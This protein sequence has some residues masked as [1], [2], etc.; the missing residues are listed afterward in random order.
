MRDNSRYKYN[1]CIIIMILIIV[2]YHRLAKYV[3]NV[4]CI[5]TGA[6][7]VIQITNYMIPRLI[8]ILPTIFELH[9]SRHSFFNIMHICVAE[10]SSM[11]NGF[12]QQLIAY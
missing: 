10:L 5:S 12:L 3:F 9:N 8:S 6:N 1:N 4:D 11:S 7:Y 2:L